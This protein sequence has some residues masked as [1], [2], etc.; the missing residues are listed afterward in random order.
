MIG[1]II[2]FVLKVEACLLVFPLIVNYLYGESIGFAY[3]VTIG[4]CFG[5]GSLLSLTDKKKNIIF[6]R[7][8]LVAVGLAWIIMSAL[9]ALPFF[10]SQE[11]PNYI[12][13]LFETISGFT[14]TGSS[15][16]N[17]V[18]ALSHANIFWRSLTHWIGGMGILVFV[19]AVASGSNERMMHVMRAESPGPT[20]GKLVP[21]MKQSAAILYNIYLF[22]TIACVIFLCLGGM[23]LFD[24]LCHAFG[25]AG[26]G[27]FG[28]KNT[29]V[30]YYDSAYI[31]AVITIFM[32]LFG[33][34][35]NVYYFILIRDFKAAFKNEEFKAYI[36]IIIACIVMIG[37]NIY[38]LYGNV[39]DVLRY[40]SF[41]VGSIITTTGYSTA[42]FDLWPSFSKM[43]LLLL[44]VL[45]ASAGSTGGGIK[46]SRFLIIVKKVKLD[47]QR[48]IHPQKV[49]AIT[50]DGKLV[51]EEVVTQITSYFCCFM[52]IM[53]T[54]LLL[55]SLDNLDME[56]TISAVM[57]CIGN[58]GPGFS[59]CGPLANFDCFSYFSKLVLSAAMLIGRLEIYPILIF[60]F[61]VIRL[62]EAIKKPKRRD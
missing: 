59:L 37:I 51:D 42:N 32:I 34:N 45:G 12:D 43:I 39:A 56:T 16:L 8:G 26:T 30:A 24:S 50:M 36:G 48:L 25:T 40:S 49:N 61:P 46:V 23:P 28:I 41:Q 13:C 18:E 17:D 27:G 3:I 44:M 2:G 62:P 52:L 9:G 31:D 53:A 1:R 29:S 19:L 15:I 21:R 7:D 6:S 5:I 60:M 10:I 38:P 20:I 22:L 55:V 11:I 35:F 47:I 57:S 58:I 54:C 14:T 33:I 4:L